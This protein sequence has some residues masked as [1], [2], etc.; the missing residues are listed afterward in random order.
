MLLL[1]ASTLVGSTDSVLVNG[2]TCPPSQCQVLG[3]L[4]EFDIILRDVCYWPAALLQDML[5]IP[6]VELWPVAMLMPMLWEGEFSLPNPVAYLPRVGM[7]FTPNMV[8]LPTLLVM[9]LVH[10]RFD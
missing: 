6:S 1:H 10:C 3:P 8:S 7:D 2:P 4:T 9:A 5:G